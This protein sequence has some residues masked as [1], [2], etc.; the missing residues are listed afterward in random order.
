VKNISFKSLQVQNF[1]SVG[2][3]P[4]ILNFNNGITLITGD[5]RDKGGRNGVGKS[6]VIESVY[7]C[8][9]GNTIREI[10]K[11]KIVHNL[12]Q[13]NCSVRLYFD[14]LSFN[15]KDE[16][17]LTR[18]AEPNKV[19]LL[20]N[21]VDVTRSSM[22]KTDELIKDLI[23]ANEEIFQ[24]A[25]IMTANNT[26]P[27]MAQKK[28]DKRKFVEGVLRLG[29]FG[30]MLLQVRSDLNDEKKNNDLVSRQFLDQQKNLDIYN[31]QYQKTENLKKQK[32]EKLENNIK[33]NTLK[34]EKNSLLTL[35]DL[36]SKINSLNQN[37]SKKESKIDQL[38]KLE[39]ECASKQTELQQQE[40]KAQHLLDSLSKE[41][42]SFL[43]KSKTCPAC[44]RPYEEG[45]DVNHI[46]SLV[47]DISTKIE[48]TKKELAGVK[49]ELKK[50]CSS[51]NTINELIQNLGKEIKNHREELHSI[52]LISKEIQHLEE[53]N[54][55]I[56]KEIEEILTTEN[57]FEN[58][59]KETQTEITNLES[60]LDKI[61][62]KISI[63][64]SAKY[65][66][67]EEGVKTFIIKKL[68]SLLNSKLNYYLQ[69]LEAPCR[70]EFNE[71]FEET[72]YNEKNMECSYFN[73]SGGERKRIDLAILFMFQDVL[74]TQ[75]GTS[76][77]LSMYD[78]LFDSAL[79]EK[80]VD[81]I[82]GILKERVEK[83]QEC[84]Y[85]VS[86]NKAATRSG[87][88]QVILLEKQAGV[89]K[90]VS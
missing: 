24:N 17:I 54:I 46:N 77:S 76:F 13:K 49:K 81:K 22:P 15:K 75:T 55:G 27:F 5:N 19:E 6:T 14:V 9:F 39:S 20:C 68:L 28:V 16:Y 21:G 18:Q 12:T 70:C 83:Y 61:Q 71:T 66:V 8:L 85:I 10:K 60:N 86:H 2:E 37:I 79:D 69:I 31:T 57:S 41:K 4:L 38:K 63:L 32:I 36:E 30:E 42:D 51:C 44:K 78:E 73:F 35:Q 62:K 80:G 33:E 11:D 65:V 74:R 64:E 50:Q 67:S 1:L 26:T 89:T 47:E 56:Q 87:I 29:V 25:V 40:Y 59:I 84:I 82:L 7:W 23:N 43:N 90:I 45:H 48:D 53:L 52:S 34:A 58:L 3:E 72:I 88:D